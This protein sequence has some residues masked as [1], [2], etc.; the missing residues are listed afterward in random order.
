MIKKGLVGFSLTGDPTQLK[1]SRQAGEFFGEVALLES[2]P[3]KSTAVAQTVR[4]PLML[5]ALAA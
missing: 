2:V 3:E 5:D 4:T 1:G